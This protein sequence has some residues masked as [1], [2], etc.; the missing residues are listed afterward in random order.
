MVVDDS[1]LHCAHI[2]HMCRQ[3]GAGQI[4]QYTGGRE[5]LWHVLAETDT[6]E[7]MIIDLE[8][9]D[10]D[11]ISLLQ[12]MVEHELLGRTAVI[13]ASAR[14]NSLLS[15]VDRLCRTMGIQLLGVLPKPVSLSHLARTFAQCAVPATRQSV[16]PASAH[17]VRDLEEALR[18]HQFVPYFQPKVTLQSAALTGVEALMRWRH[19]VDGVVA[20][21][22]FIPLLEESLLIAPATLDLIELSLI[23]LRAWQSAGLTTPLSINLSTR[24]LGDTAFIDE[25]LRLV[26]IHATDPG[27]LTFEVTETAIM[28]DLDKSI[29][30]MARLRMKG[31]GLSIDD[32]GTGFASMRQLSRAPFTELKIDR[33]LVHDSHR[34]LQLRVVIETIVDLSARLGLKLVAEGIE[35]INDWLVLRSLHCETAQGYLI[36]RPMPGDQLIEW[37]AGNHDPLSSA[38]SVRGGTPEGTRK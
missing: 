13:I 7:L 8:M 18:C 38:N 20:P 23:Q 31:F 17:S 6:P 21:G 30:N 9:P 11:G 1:P 5:A 33:S 4:T 32:F 28:S 35:D 27:M 36:A 26:R 19:P 25:M 14:E 15:S 24:L 29:G 10:M 22:Q 12:A 34:R 2:S 16:T 37:V 3:L